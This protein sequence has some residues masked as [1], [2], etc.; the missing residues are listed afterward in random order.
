MARELLDLCDGSRSTDQM[1]E[2]FAERRQLSP[3]D[4]PEHREQVVAALQRLYDQR[5]LVFCGTAP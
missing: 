1:L 2:T 4:L 3:A 5:I